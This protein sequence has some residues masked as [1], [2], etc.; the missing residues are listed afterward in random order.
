LPRGPATPQLVVSY[1][2]Q[3]AFLAPDG[4]V[5]V[6]GGNPSMGSMASP[7]G[8]PN[9]VEV[10][11]RLDAGPHWRALAM[12]S[13]AIDGLKNDSTRWQWSNRGPR[14][15][16]SASKLSSA[17]QI[18]TDNDWAD[19]SGM[20]SHFMALKKDGTLWGWGQNE[21]GQIGNGEGVVDPSTSSQNVTFR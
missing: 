8:G 5:W 1:N 18:G 7:A 12:S 2:G 9:M 10:P 19:V 13:G 11:Q 6:W 21:S 15:A 3:A 17:S 20:V 14:P 4:S 16:G